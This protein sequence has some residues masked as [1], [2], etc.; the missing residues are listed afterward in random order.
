MTRVSGAWLDHAGGQAVIA[1]LEAAGQ[2]AYFVGGCV[3]DGLLD[4][5]VRDVDIATDA[6][7]D[8]VQSV[9]QAA[10]FKTVPTGIDH[11]TVTVLA[12]GRPHEVTTFRSDQETDG[13]HATVRF[14]TDVTEDAARRDFTMNALY[15]GR[16]GTILD[17]LG[18]LDDLRSGH[19]RFIGT[20]EARI[21]EDYLRILRFFRFTAWYGDPAL[22]IDGEGLA[23]C[24][25]LADGIARLSAERVG[26]EMLKLLAFCLRGGP[27]KGMYLAQILS[28]TFVILTSMGALGALRDDRFRARSAMALLATAPWA[29]YL[30][31]LALPES[32]SMCYLGLALLWLRRWL[33]DPTA[34]S[35][36]CIALMLGGAM[37]TGYA[38]GAVV[39]APGLVVMLAVGLRRGRML[40]QAALAVAAVLVLLAPWAVRNVAATGNPVFPWG[41]A[42]LGAGHW[43]DQTARRWRDAHA[44]SAPADSDALDAL[45]QRRLS[46]REKLTA[47]LLE[48][49]RARGILRNRNIPG[50]PVLG[51]GVLVLLIGTLGAMFIRPRTVPRWDWALLTV[52]ILQMAVWLA[53]APAAPAR[54]VSVCAVTISLLCAGGLARL[55]GVRE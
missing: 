11:G 26:A 55:A 24:A 27:Y 37:A 43:P 9:A 32:A 16:S 41:T 51:I 22:G 33:A 7:P 52:L 48:P 36:G 42:V 34:R 2:A 38:A 39:A 47:F 50:H 25:A 5:P 8:K 53:L 4:R 18:G 23:A 20:A 14:G 1:A 45:T 3:R 40:S 31:G 15:A 35:T 44:G 17:P 30:A 6:L 54:F 29:L 49:F 46:V 21:R 13:R 10:G 19:L 12:H 28:G